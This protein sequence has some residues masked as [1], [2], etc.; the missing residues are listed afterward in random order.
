MAPL[1]YY[2]RYP[3]DFLDA[4]IGMPFELKAA[5]GLILDL[6]YL[7]GG[8]LKYDA[9]YISG[10]LGCSVRQVKS[11]VDELVSREK[12]TLFEGIISNFRA[13][14]ELENARKICEKNRENGT[15]SKKNNDL[16][17]RTVEPKSNH[18]EI[19]S[20][21][22]DLFKKIEPNGSTKKG[23]RIS[24]DWV[25]SEAGIKFAHDL[26]GPFGTSEIDAFRDY[27][28]GKT[29]ANATKLDWEATW[30]NWVRSNAKRYRPNQPPKKTAEQIL[31]ERDAR[32]GIN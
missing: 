22:T 2:K 31:A 6:I 14:F 20:Q 32:R 13:T 30:R 11:F 25:P 17:K 23:C 3:R 26:L 1:P 18:I 21:N 12:L 29:G 15:Q 8:N 5:Y 19:Q 28:I 16:E 10:Q 7:H 24:P 27:W 4:T 9:R